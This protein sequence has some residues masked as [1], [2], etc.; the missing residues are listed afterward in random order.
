MKRY[1]LIGGCVML[2]LGGC[3]PRFYP[4][5][6]DL[7][8]Q[9]SNSSSE[10]GEVELRNGKWWCIFG[11]RVLDSLV[12][13]ALKANRNLAQAAFRVE[14]VRH[15]MRVARAAYLPSVGGSASAG[16]EYDKTRT[17]GQ[18]YSLGGSLSWEISLFGALRNT[19]RQARARIESAEWALKGMRLSVAAEVATTYF[20]LLE[21]ER[22]LEIATRSLRLRERSAALVDSLFTYGF[23]DGV[24]LSQAQSLVYSAQTDIPHFRHAVEQARVSLSVLLGETPEKTTW[25]LSREYLPLDSLPREIPAGVPSD[26]LRRRPDIVQSHYELLE[27]AAGVGLARSARFPSIKLT[28]GGGAA[29]SSLKELTQEGWWTWNAG[30]NILMPIFNFGRLRRA[31]QAAMSRYKQ[32][33]CG[34]EQQVLEALSE[35][36]TALTAIEEQRR[37]IHSSSELMMANAEIARMTR[38]LYR[39][40][41]SNY[42]DVID[43]ERSLYSSQMQ[44]VNLRAGQYINYINL[45]KALGGGW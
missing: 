13:R 11:D 18:S 6:T 30:G 41:F 35:V 37:Q 20:T 27:A 39:S 4:P 23:A 44:Q 3:A 42:L 43:A 5:K 14:E 9:Y 8:P 7:A 45:I 25:T 34:Y 33:V 38:A 10:V 24:A 12:E 31:E 28:A 29:S 1:L 36:E 19:N 2:L 22:D 40:G 32:A 16:A 15:T 17:T 21:Y 26:L